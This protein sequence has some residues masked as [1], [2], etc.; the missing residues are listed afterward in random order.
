MSGYAS[1]GR[2]WNEIAPQPASRTAM[3]ST[4]NL[5]FSAK[6]TRA[7]IIACPVL[8]ANAPAQLLLTAAALGYPSFAVLLRPD[9]LLHPLLSEH[10]VQHQR[11]RN[12]LLP[13]LESGLDF[14]Q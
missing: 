4:T 8:F 11:V 12:Y 10:V 13:W 6:S 3:A 1:T 7:R 2:L 9:T 14:L 5:L